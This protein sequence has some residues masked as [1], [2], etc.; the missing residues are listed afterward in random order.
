MLRIASDVN[1]LGSE[2]YVSRS[3]PGDNSNGAMKNINHPT[4]WA[5]IL[6]CP[7]ARVV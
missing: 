2:K 3:L 1:I 4:M 5:E 6:I 7:G